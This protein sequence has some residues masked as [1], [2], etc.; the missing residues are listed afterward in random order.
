MDEQRLEILKQCKKDL[1]FFG[2]EIS[3]QTF[4]LSSPDFHREIDNLLMDRSITQLMI[5]APRGTGKSTKCIHF[6]LHHAIFDIG[7]K[8]IV[9]QSKTR[10]EAIRRLT[11]IKDIIE[12]G[13]KFRSL[14][15][16]CG[17]QAAISWREDYVK[18]KIGVNTVT[19]IAVGTGQQVRGILE[20]DTRITLYYLDDPDDEDNTKSKEGMEDNFSKFLGGIAGLDRRYGRVIVVGTPITEGCIV[21]RVRDSAGWVTKNYAACDEETKECLWE[22][23]YDFNWLMNKKKELDEQGMLWK[24]YSEYMCQLRGKDDQVFKNE[25]FRF[26]DGE[27]K[28]GIGT[29]HFLLIKGIYDE[30]KNPIELYDEPKKIAILTFIGIDPSFSLNP[31]ADFSV[32]MPIGVDKDWNIY[33]FPY[34]RKR[35]LTTELVDNIVHQHNIFLPSKTTIESGAQQDTVRQM[36]NHLQTKHIVGLASKVAPPKDSKHKRYIDIL[37]YYHKNHKLF[38]NL[39]NSDELKSEMILHPSPSAHDDTIDA[40]YWAVKRAF[41]PDHDVQEI[42]TDPNIFFLPRKKEQNYSWMS[43]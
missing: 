20:G 5:E 27:F 32:V 17:E 29:E 19:I 8:V 31:R 10:R 23:M 12:Y 11:K 4:Y 33:Q 3:P 9:I 14:F 16:Y 22:E 24:F 40:L 13:Q 37:Q 6:V 35:I 18:T 30:Y 25:D 41:T 28:K 34:I 1:E 42:T 2:K 7:D 21:A 15:G 36:V 38:L 26:W 39:N 43:A